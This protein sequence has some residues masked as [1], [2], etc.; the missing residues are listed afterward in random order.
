MHKQCLCM[1]GFQFTISV[2]H[3]S[4][5]CLAA[6]WQTL[7]LMLYIH[8]TSVCHDKIWNS[9]SPYNDQTFPGNKLEYK[10]KLSKKDIVLLKQYLQLIVKLKIRKPPATVY[11]SAM[12]F[13][14]ST[15]IQ[16][17][18]G[19][20]S[21]KCLTMKEHWYIM[22]IAT[23]QVGIVSNWPFFPACLASPISAIAWQTLI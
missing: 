16:R 1:A 2:W 14:I 8:V 21:F 18:A 6:G 10:V 4:H 5:A 15:Q 11:C 23:G 12:F 3:L 9:D 22:A 17:D 13:K 19:G 20:C 7:L